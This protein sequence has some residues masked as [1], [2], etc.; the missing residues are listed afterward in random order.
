[1]SIQVTVAPTIS[2]ANGGEASPAAAS[3]VAAP[4]PADE[5]TGGGAGAQAAA[6]AT[7]TPRTTDLERD[8]GAIWAEQLGIA[9]GKIGVHTSFFE[10][11]GNSLSIMGVRTALRLT[12]GLEVAIADLFQHSTI[13]QL[14]RYI[15]GGAAP[16][17]Q[18]GAELRDAR[19]RMLKARG[20]QRRG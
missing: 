20:L 1:M 7:G 16:P 14:A 5:A 10:L 9:S 11:G 2:L 4:L 12:M 3:P 8:L 19:D 13:Y 6:D 18:R 15:E 17:A